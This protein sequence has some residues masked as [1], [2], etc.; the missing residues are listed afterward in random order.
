M[1]FLNGLPVAVIELKDP[2]DEQAD[3]WKAYHQLQ[4]YKEHVP[5]LFTYNELMV[6]SDRDSTRLGSLTAGSDR[7]APWRSIEDAARPSE[8]TLEAL[9]T[10]LFAPQRLLDYLLNC[11]ISS[12]VLITPVLQRQ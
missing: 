10:G 2:A 6:V 8:P 1:V 4:D 9:A 5:A 11:V 12:T 7:F 3:L